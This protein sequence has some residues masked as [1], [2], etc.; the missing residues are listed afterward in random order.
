MASESQNE[1]QINADTQNPD[2]EGGDEASANRVDGVVIQAPKPN[3]YNPATKSTVRW[4]DGET[5]PILDALEN[6]KDLL[7]GHVKDNEYRR[8]RLN[9]WAAL[10]ADVNQWNADNNTGVVRSVTSIRARIHNLKSRSKCFFPFRLKMQHAEAHVDEAECKKYRKKIFLTG[11]YMLQGHCKGCYIATRWPKIEIS[12]QK[13]QIWSYKCWNFLT[14]F[15]RPKPVGGSLR[16][17]RR[18]VWTIRRSFSRLLSIL[19]TYH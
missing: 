18:P 11:R 9:T 16:T 13:W 19:G 6:S 2:E 1:D 17:I 3:D 5:V 14:D 4:Q 10:L 12:V 7:I 8:I 15:Q